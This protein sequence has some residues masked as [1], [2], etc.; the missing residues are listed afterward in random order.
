AVKR[1]YVA[2]LAR[3]FPVIFEMVS[4]GRLHLSGLIVLRRHFTRRNATE[5]LAAATYRTVAEIR[6]FKARRFPEKD[7]PT[8]IIPVARSTPSLRAVGPATIQAQLSPEKVDTSPMEVSGPA[9]RHVMTESQFAAV[10]EPEY[11]TLT[12]SSPERFKLRMTIGQET[13]D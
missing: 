8:Q 4:D 12:P 1:I 13:H 11:P 10:P 3:Q 7:V 9:E 2:R 6:L 5:L